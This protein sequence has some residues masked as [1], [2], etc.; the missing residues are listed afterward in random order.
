MVTTAAADQTARL[1]DAETGEQ[2]AGLQGHDASFRASF[3]PDGRR[4]LTGSHLFTGAVG[5]WD[6]ETGEQV[7]FLQAGIDSLENSPDGRLGV[8]WSVND[9]EARLW[10]TETGE[11]I[12]VLQGH[13]EDILCASF[14]PDGQWV[15]TGSADETARVWDISRTRPML[16]DRAVAL[17]AALAQGIGQRTEAERTDLL[18]QDAPEDLYAEARMQLLDPE[19]YS[20]EEIARR[21]KL[22]KQTIADLRAPLH[23]NCYLSPTQFA[24]LAP[25]ASPQRTSST[26]TAEKATGDH[27]LRSPR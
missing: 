11:Q 23:P 8:A 15:L 16:R 22:L 9:K 2:V 7:A 10:D 12:A 27:G 4:V 26:E 17:T 14:S 21:E 13:D 5:L 1:W 6:A 25:P 24:G 3:S 20:P 19:K 18:M